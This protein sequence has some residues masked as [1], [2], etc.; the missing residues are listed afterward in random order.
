MS[1]P[2]CAE[3]DS[4]VQIQEQFRDSHQKRRTKNIYSISF[5]ASDDLNGVHQL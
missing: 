1:C 5:L 4:T 2:G 3:H